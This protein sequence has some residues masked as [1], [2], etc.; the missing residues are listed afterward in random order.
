MLV[1]R[2]SR[3]SGTSSLISVSQAE[4]PIPIHRPRQATA[5]TASGYQGESA[6]T[7]IPRSLIPNAAKQIATRLRRGCQ[8]AQISDPATIPAAIALKRKPYAPTPRW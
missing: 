7:T 5:T 2:E 4:M 3:C 8:R 1:T 6:R